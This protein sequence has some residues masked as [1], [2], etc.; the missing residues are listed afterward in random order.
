MKKLILIFALSC[1]HKGEF[2]PLTDYTYSPEKRLLNFVT[3]ACPRLTNTQ[4][5]R[6]S[7]V[8]IT[9]DGLII[10]DLHVT[11][12]DEIITIDF[13][14]LSPDDNNFLE[15]AF[16]TTGHVV[17]FSDP[18]LDFTIIKADALP[19]DI[20]PLPLAPHNALEA[21]QP[22]WRFGYNKS[23]RW[24]YGYFIAADADLTGDYIGKK[25]I[26]S[27]GP[28]SSGGPIVNGR[29]QVLGIIQ[30][31]YD[32]TNTVILDN[33]KR[34]SMHNPAIAYFMPIEMIRGL[35]LK[36][37]QEKSLKIEGF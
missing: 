29:G 12:T 19:A 20:K 31:G 2:L 7:G 28:G 4:G 34:C 18:K 26:I 16:T 10:T 8:L 27:G 5:S 14:K 11:D 22:V 15:R 21:D 9:S 37:T 1:G 36:A 30:K 32:C 6:G 23:Y 13:F 25:M 3:Q 17:F 33:G 35:L 24:S